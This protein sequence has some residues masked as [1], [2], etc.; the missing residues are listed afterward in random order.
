MCLYLRK[1]KEEE[2]RK[3]SSCLQRTRALQC[4]PGL[5]TSLQE[6]PPAAERIGGYASPD[7]T[8]PTD[9]R[10]GGGLR[11]TLLRQR[12]CAIMDGIPT[13]PCADL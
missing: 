8:H 10:A 2:A 5:P 11:Q 7:R 3:R 12:N 6:R 1:I 13:S 4:A 9:E